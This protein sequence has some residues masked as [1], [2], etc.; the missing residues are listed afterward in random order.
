MGTP[1]SAVP[2]LEALCQR[3]DVALVVTQPDRPK[4]RSGRPVPPPVKQ[5]ATAIGLEVSQPTNRR[6]LEQVLAESGPFD[7]GVVVAFGRILTPEVLAIPDRGFLNVHFSLLPRW[8]GAAPVSRALLAGDQMTGVTI[9]RLDEGLDTGPVLT[10]QAV[11]IDPV[12][13][14]GELTMSLATLGSRLLVDTLPRYMSGEMVPVPQTDEG[15]TYAEKIG[16]ADRVISPSDRTATTV[17]RVRALAPRPAA[18]IQIDGQPHKILAASRSDV[19]P[20]R[21]TWQIVGGAPILGMADGGVELLTIQPP[22]KTPQEGR[23]WANGRH[24]TAGIIG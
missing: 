22:G 9:I 19:S 21:G 16:K 20:P 6:E 7:V 11:D 18:T 8:R 17:D 3:N 5:A 13:N 4:G 14:A 10:A 15:A 1:Q 2:T 12:A 23:S 24:E